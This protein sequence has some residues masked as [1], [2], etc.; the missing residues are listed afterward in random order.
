MKNVHLK[1]MRLVK[2]IVIDYDTFEELT[3]TIFGC[4]STVDS[5]IGGLTI[6]ILDKQELIMEMESDDINKKLS[7]YFDV[8]VTSIHVDDNDDVWIAY[9]EKKK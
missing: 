3:E 4:G 9:E 6:S 7:A 1:P 5:T 2:S 8:K